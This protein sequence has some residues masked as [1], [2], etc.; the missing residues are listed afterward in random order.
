MPLLVHPGTEKVFIFKSEDALRD[1]LI[2]F[3][4]DAMLDGSPVHIIF[5][6]GTQAPLIS[7]SDGHHLD[8]GPRSP[9]DL[10]ATIELL[11]QLAPDLKANFDQPDWEA[12]F[13]ECK[14]SDQAMRSREFT[15]IALFAVGAVIAY[16][17]LRHV[18][19]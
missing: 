8:W 7:S 11:K 10:P 5:P 6:D 4:P 17:A 1:R 3:A 15:R 18:I 14:A 2:K 9:A 19:L 12:L 16:Y 13:N